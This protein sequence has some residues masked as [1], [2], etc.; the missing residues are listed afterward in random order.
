MRQEVEVASNSLRL[1]GLQVDVMVF[2]VAGGCD[3]LF[4][5]EEMPVKDLMLLLLVKEV[6]KEQEAD[7]ERLAL[8]IAR[9]RRS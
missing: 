3:L 5:V 7:F 4:E 9:C 1:V 6:E 2:Q 8:R